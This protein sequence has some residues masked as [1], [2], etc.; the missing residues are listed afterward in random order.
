MRVLLFVMMTMN[1]TTATETII[2]RG[3]DETY[4]CDK[5][6]G[7]DYNVY[8]Y[9]EVYLSDT[10]HVYDY[11]DASYGHPDSYEDETRDQP[12]IKSNDVYIAPAYQPFY[13]LPLQLGPVNSGPFNFK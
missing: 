6:N 10:I 1:Y 11:S 13:F 2:C 8:D 9:A 4:E 5:Y 3:Q 12:R 7:D